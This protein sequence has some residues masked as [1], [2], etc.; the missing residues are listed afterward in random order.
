[1]R[2]CAVPNGHV[3]CTEFV[4]EPAYLAIG[5]AETVGGPAPGENMPSVKET[6]ECFGR[7][8]EGEVHGR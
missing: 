3:G 5:D 1:V 2:V 6:P 4:E 8:G 7:T